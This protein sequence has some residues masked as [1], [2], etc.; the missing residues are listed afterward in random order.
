MPYRRVKRGDCLSSIAAEAG[1]RW[2]YLWDLPEN[3]H[4]RERGD[5]NVLFPG[6]E[7]F[8]PA[9]RRR[10]ESAGT[11]DHHRYRRKDV[12]LLLR[13]EL[14]EGD[15]VRAH[16]SCVLE[17][18]GR[19]LEDSTDGDGYVEFRVP[20]RARNATLYVG[21][22]RDPYPLAV[23]AL[24]PVSESTGVQA[25]LNNLGFPCGRIDGLVGRRTRAALRAFQSR[26]E[27]EITG[28][29]DEATR[30]ELVRRHGC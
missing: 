22:D 2:R 11:D 1:F 21:E 15:A 26:C 6:D 13:L 5:P 25:R 4:L 24:D 14:R 3:A 18:E 19:Q 9:R 29:P 27:L 10:E 30:Q 20:P 12:P 7:V 23:G 16:E 8:V 17:I 28:R